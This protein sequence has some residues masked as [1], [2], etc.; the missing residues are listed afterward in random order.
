MENGLRL[1]FFW[2]FL[3][4]QFSVFKGQK[5]W[6]CRGHNCRPHEKYS[7]SPLRS[8]HKCSCCVLQMSSSNA[9]YPH[10]QGPSGT[11]GSRMPKS[12]SKSRLWRWNIRDIQKKSSLR[13]WSLRTHFTSWNLL[14]YP[15]KMSHFREHGSLKKFLT[16]PI[17]WGS[18]YLL[19]C[20]VNSKSTE[21]FICTW[22]RWGLSETSSNK[23]METTKWI[24]K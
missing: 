7:T 8:R 2:S 22:S 14:K 1:L 9:S 15:P 6:I 11:R 24:Y 3:W 5:T 13:L 16:S 10:P 21:E 4:L 20:R 12:T 19:T 23:K 17:S 18:P